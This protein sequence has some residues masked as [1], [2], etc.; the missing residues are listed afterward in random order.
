MNFS[1]WAMK[2][3]WA[4]FFIF[5]INSFALADE[6]DLLTI[7]WQ[8]PPANILPET[9][10]EQ[11]RQLDMIWR[12]NFKTG[13]NPGGNT[14]ALSAVHPEEENLEGFWNFVDHEFVP[15][16]LLDLPVRAASWASEDYLVS[17]LE[18]ED[19]SLFMAGT[20]KNTGRTFIEMDPLPVTGNVLALSPD[21]SKLLILAPYTREQL[22]LILSP[23]SQNLVK[24]RAEISERESTKVKTIKIPSKMAAYDEHN[25]L[26]VTAEDSVLLLVDL[27]NMQVHELIVIEAAS[28][29]PTASFSPDGKNL[30][31][32]HNYMGDEI[33]SIVR[34]GSF[35]QS[36]T[37]V[38]VQ[39]ALGLVH[40]EENPLHTN[41]SV[42]FFDVQNPENLPP[43]TVEAREVP[44]FYPRFHDYFKPEWS[45]CGDQVVL[46]TVHPATLEGRE[47]PVY[48]E[49]ESSSYLVL[50]TDLEV[51]HIIDTAPLSYPG[52]VARA[53]WLSSQEMIF[54]LIDGMDHAV[55]KYNLHNGTQT[56]LYKNGVISS[57]LLLPDQRSMYMIV[58][59]A[60][61]ASELWTINLDS[62]EALQVTEMNKDISRGAGVSVHPVEFT[63]ESGKVKLGYWFAP[64]DMAWPPRN[65][66]VVF[67]QAGGPGSPMLN[68]WSYRVEYP[69]TLLPSMGISVLM[70]PLQERPGLDSENWKELANGQNFGNVDIDQMAEIA[71]QLKNNGWASGRGVGITGC[72]YGGYMTSQSIV[73]YPDLWDAAVTQCSLLDLHT[74]FQMGYAA[75]VAYLMGS[76]PWMAREHYFQASPGFHGSKVKTPTLVFHG[77]DDFLPV[78]IAQNFFYDIH[79]AGTPARML[80]F[81]GEEHGLNQDANAF[82]AAQEQIR[83]FRNY[84]Q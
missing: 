76:V 9:E 3:A 20:N 33:E 22:M 62:G 37:Q 60:A 34:Q 82:Y 64:K 50:N 70:I 65:E 13:V 23:D 6:P 29:I 10:L 35:V 43:R 49:T 15:S 52:Q 78:G 42:L 53:V 67:W 61:S 84:L 32:V 55:Y 28:F 75:H 5:G 44:G 63:L 58:Q 27:N 77:V 25:D 36:L 14:A 11:I 19:E 7:N 56:K 18:E 24:R 80:R 46:M 41:S 4:I 57:S 73:R 66:Q 39:D 54:T 30:A 51:R 81:L 12:I 48:F 59:S 2:L 83:W 71:L 79:A 40:P 26:E 69:L 1:F 8:D 16:D 47:M 68:T 21:A 31:V 72:S 17:I 74:E 38:Q 45:P